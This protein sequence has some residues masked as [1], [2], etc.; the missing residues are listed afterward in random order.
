MG[1]L[2]DCSLSDSNIAVNVKGLDAK[3]K[4][5]TAGAKHTCALLDDDRVMCWGDNTEGQLGSY[6]E[7]RYGTCQRSALSSD[8]PGQD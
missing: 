5:V 7:E 3:A 8:D 6:P 2:G 1:Q 4:L